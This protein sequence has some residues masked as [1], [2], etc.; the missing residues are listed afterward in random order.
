MTDPRPM[1]ERI[2]CGDRHKPLNAC[3]DCYYRYDKWRLVREG[4]EKA[5]DIN[6]FGSYPGV[7]EG[8][9]SHRV[10]PLGSAL[11]N[12]LRFVGEDA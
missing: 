5:N 3:I 7:S 11:G 9:Y 8:V 2:K 4:K 12:A 10:L 1:C 6:G